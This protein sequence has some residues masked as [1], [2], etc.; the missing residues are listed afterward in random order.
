M[1]KLLALLCFAPAAAFA[2][3][4]PGPSATEG[5]IGAVMTLL[6]PIVVKVLRDWWKDNA[7]RRLEKVQMVAKLAF[8]LTEEAKRLWPDKVPN[9][10]LFA[11]GKFLELLRAQGI[12]PT[13]AE[14]T[15]AKAT[16]GATNGVETVTARLAGAVSTKDVQLTPE[17]KPVP[18]Q[19]PSL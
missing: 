18:F 1:S 6:V 19:L 2:D 10:L 13:P 14:I 15:L 7:D 12:N 16:W 3:N 5:L 8:W 11:E 4:V 17:V 9:A